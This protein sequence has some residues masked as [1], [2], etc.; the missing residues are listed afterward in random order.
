MVQRL[1]LT[2]N[3]NSIKRLATTGWM[4]EGERTPF[5]RMLA[6]SIGSIG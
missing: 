4:D 3:G 5:S 2:V 6:R 1:T